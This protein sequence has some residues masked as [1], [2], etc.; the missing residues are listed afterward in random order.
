MKNHFLKCLC[1]ALLLALTVIPISV[2][3]QD[4][5]DDVWSSFDEQWED[6]NTV[7]NAQWDAYEQKQ[8]RQ[9]EEFK[10]SVE[11]KWDTFMD[12]TK[13]T[14]VD[15]NKDL[16][17]RSLVDFENGSIEVTAIVPTDS[18]DAMKQGKEQIYSQVKKMF[19][20]QNPAGKTV[21]QDQLRNK[22]GKVVTPENLDSY[23]KKEIVPNIQVGQTPYKAKDGLERQKLT[24]NLNLVPNHIQVRAEK[25]IDPVHVQAQKM[26]IEPELILAV[27][28]TESYFNPMAKSH[29]G[30]YGL[31]QLIPKYGAR[32]AY[33]FLYKEEKL[34]AP[35][36]LYVPENNIELGSAYLHILK[37]KYYGDVKDDAKNSYLSICSYNWGPGAVKRS[38]SK[39]G[40]DVNRV[41]SDQ[42]YTF[43][44]AHAPEE[45]SNYLKKVTERRQMYGRMY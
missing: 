33:G 24:V 7:S 5:S 45:T 30:A 17:A 31:M 10:A 23:I 14:W 19:S 20:T 28:H 22:K 34:L 4:S 27:I 9:W 11:R 21:L 41:S 25:F 6:F 40:I 1:L 13:K 26:K 29:A 37:D 32:E 18:T 15:Y 35:E 3:G 39:Y 38:L 16:D 43:L 8:Q 44:R 42:L 36:Y 12:S 2:A